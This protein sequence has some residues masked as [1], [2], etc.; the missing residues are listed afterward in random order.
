MSVGV[1]TIALV[2]AGVGVGTATAVGVGGGVAVAGGGVGGPA[3]GG[4]GVGV[5][6]G[7]ARIAEVSRLLSR[8]ALSCFL[9][10]LMGIEKFVAE[11]TSPPETTRPMEFTP[12]TL[13]WESINGPPA[14]P[15]SSEALVQMKFPLLDEICPRVIEGWVP[16]ELASRVKPTA[17][18]TSPTQASSELPIG[19]A[20]NPWSSATSMYATPSSSSIPISSPLTVSPLAGRTLINQLPATTCESVTTM[21]SWPATNPDPAPMSVIIWTT[22]VNAASSISD[23][24]TWRVSV[25]SACRV[26]SGWPGTAVTGEIVPAGVG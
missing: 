10:G 17:K 26:H 25:D 16:A 1:G 13:P 11:V 18:A 8:P 23:S 24:V 14:A 19:R 3:G 2:G 12:M 21:P 7:A 9:T 15:E 5:G 20:A 22:P 4:R 6:R